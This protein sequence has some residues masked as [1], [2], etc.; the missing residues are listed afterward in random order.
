MRLRVAAQPSLGRN[1]S[2]DAVH[3]RLERGLGLDVGRSPPVSLALGREQQVVGLA[4]DGHH[5]ATDDL[6]R[7]RQPRQEQRCGRR[8]GRTGAQEA[9]S[10]CTG[11]GERAD[12]GE[13]RGE[14]EDG[15]NERKRCREETRPQPPPQPA[16]LPGTCEGVD[17]GERDGRRQRLAQHK[18]HVVLRPRVDGVQQPRDQGHALSPPAANREH[19]EV[20]AE[21][22]QRG[23]SDQGERMVAADDL[24]LAERREV[25]WVA[26]RPEG[27][28]LGRLPGRLRDP[29]AGDVE[30]ALREYVVEARLER[31]RVGA[32]AERVRGGDVRPRVGLLVRA[33]ERDV[34]EPVEP[35]GDSQHERRAPKR[36]AA[37]PHGGRL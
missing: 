5:R 35:G 8:G 28:V 16:A 6:V 17:P 30:P 10:R 14:D 11:R 33:H 21:R 13:R 2:A 12:D 15:S 18:S 34:Q 20:R 36:P 24:L 23:L 1:R 37:V 25:E 22:E 19:E 7:P 26:G 27:L 29:R 3:A 9:R 32:V 31:R 4:P